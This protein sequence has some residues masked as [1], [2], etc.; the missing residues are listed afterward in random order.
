MDDIFYMSPK[1]VSIK[2]IN[3]IAKRVNVKS[4]F[5]P[6]SLDFLEIEYYDGIMANW[7]LM[8]LED[9]QELEDKKFLMDNKI[10]SIFCISYHSI[11]FTLILPHIKTLLQEYEGWIGNDGDGFQPCFNLQNIDLF[12][13]VST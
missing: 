7:F 13:Y 3:E 10:K 1:K 12:H 9:F 5:I 6:K 8:N 11:N 4:T 2:D